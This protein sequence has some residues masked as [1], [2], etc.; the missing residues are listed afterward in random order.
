MKSMTGFGKASY[1]DEHFEVEVEVKS[2]NHRFLDVRVLLPREIQSLEMAL[3]ESIAASIRRGKVDVRVTWRDKRIPRM[4]IDRERLLAL[5]RLFNEARELVGQQQQISLDRLL[6]HP[7]I[8][9]E[10]L[11]ETGDDALL[12]AIRKPLVQALA[13]HAA[14]ADK[15]GEAMQDFFISSLTR[16][17]SALAGIEAEFPEYRVELFNKYKTQVSDIL[18][19]TLTEDDTR[20]LLIETALFV[21]KA[22]INE[23]IVRLRDHIAK[24][25]DRLFDE[26]GDV[27][28]SLNF[29]LQEMQRE[30]NTI[31]AKFN[32]VK[33]FGQVL[34]IKEEIEKCR[35]LV[36]NV[37]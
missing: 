21:E 18:Q 14:M 16:M 29:I 12:E 17:D 4:E 24:F 25:R 23:E 3:R 36:Q 32:S 15:E 27:G 26:N 13:A 33:V 10:E 30:A 20:R 19:S 9:S 31:G 2:L 5:W 11:E 22:D 35:E 1:A 37:E 34:T 28:K 8:I 7:G 6:E